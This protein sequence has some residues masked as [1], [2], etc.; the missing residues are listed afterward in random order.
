MVVQ[1]TPQLEA[2]IEQL[3]ASGHFADAGDVIDKAVQLLE[4]RERKLARL[5]ELLA[6][7]EEDE[8]NGNVIEL[9]PELFEEIKQSARRRAQAGEKPS[10]HVCP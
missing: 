8:R 6:E 5:R 7:G 10:A 3:V 4:E 9:T 2:K 1:V